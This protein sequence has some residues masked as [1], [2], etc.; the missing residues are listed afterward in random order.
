MSTTKQPVVKSREYVL[1]LAQ[2]RAEVQTLRGQLSPLAA[3]TR[4]KIKPDLLRLEY[5]ARV[6]ETLRRTADTWG[7]EAL[8]ALARLERKP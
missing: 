8:D 4:A 7:R 6:D 2:L 5:L 3:A 1:L